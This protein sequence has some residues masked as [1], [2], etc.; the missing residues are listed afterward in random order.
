MMLDVETKT[1]ITGIKLS[2]NEKKVIK[3]L[4]QLLK[5]TCDCTSSCSECWIWTIYD[6]AEED[7]CEAVRNFLADIATEENGLY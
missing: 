4:R 1:T 2:D 3:D 5:R 7:N 6:H